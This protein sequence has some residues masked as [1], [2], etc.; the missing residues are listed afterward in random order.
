MFHILISVWGWVDLGVI[1]FPVWVYQWK[2]PVT[3][4]GIQTATLWCTAPTICI[5]VWLI[6]EEEKK[7]IVFSSYKYTLPFSQ[8]LPLSS[9]LLSIPA[10]LILI[11]HIFKI[12][13][14]IIFTSKDISSKWCICFI[15]PAKRLCAYFLSVMHST[16]SAHIVLDTPCVLTPSSMG[17]FFLQFSKENGGYRFNGQN[18]LWRLS[19]SK[20]D[21]H[22]LSK[23][24]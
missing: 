15:I 6:V 14:N 17:N 11:S 16:F 21:P 19:F 24:L 20:S 13:I 3:S 9:M 1:L 22:C 18:R 8:R 5:S 23:R 4:S 10:G 2:F 12:H 7:F